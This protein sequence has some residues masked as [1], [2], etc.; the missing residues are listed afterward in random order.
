MGTI[1]KLV[2]SVSVAMAAYAL[3][4]RPRLL[5]WGATDAEVR[6]PYPGAE[7]IPGGTRSA[8]NAITIDAPRRSRRSSHFRDSERRRS[9]LS[10]RGRV[11]GCE[12]ARVN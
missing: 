10:P 3:L 6:R 8:T 1:R 7:L 9:P 12:G 2:I 11:A 5:R 4:I